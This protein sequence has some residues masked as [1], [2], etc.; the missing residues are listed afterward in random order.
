VSNV[1]GTISSV[2]KIVA[3][4]KC[5]GAVVLLDSAQALAHV[6]IDVQDIDCDFLVAS[7]N[8]F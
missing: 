3:L 2:K 8:R 6:P 5:Y 1:L 4:A 7:S